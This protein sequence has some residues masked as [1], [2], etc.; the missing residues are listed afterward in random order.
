[1]HRLVLVRWPN[2]RGKGK[3]EGEG[4]GKLAE[5]QGKNKKLMADGK[6]DQTA[7]ICSAKAGKS[8]DLESAASASSSKNAQLSK[9]A[10]A[11]SAPL[12]DTQARELL[13]RVTSYSTLLCM[14]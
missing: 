2:L 6:A 11:Y 13:S 7:L 8:D 5:A 9:T 10:K 4:E 1:V 3:G 14:Y 12:S